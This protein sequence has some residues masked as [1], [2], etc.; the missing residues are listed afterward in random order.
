M[1]LHIYINNNGRGKDCLVDS[2]GLD[3]FCCYFLDNYFMVH[4]VCI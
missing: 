4:L 1:F 2:L 3:L